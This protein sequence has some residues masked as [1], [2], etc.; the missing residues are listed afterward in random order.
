[1]VVNL[2]LEE[3][4]KE[5]LL[6][7]DFIGICNDI[8]QKLWHNLNMNTFAAPDHVVRVVVFH[9]MFANGD[10]E[11]LPQEWY[12]SGKCRNRKSVYRYC[13]CLKDIANDELMISCTSAG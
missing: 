1:M 6:L 2:F 10:T 8:V 11:N 5:M 3:F 9:Y 4:H 13:H 12:C 7:Q